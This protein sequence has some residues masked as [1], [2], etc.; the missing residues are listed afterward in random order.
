MK[1]KLHNLRTL[2]IGQENESDQI[3]EMATH[4]TDFCISET[5]L[6]SFK[7]LVSLLALLYIT[8]LAPQG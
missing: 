3:T 2:T 5:I 7:F 4:I 6:Y 1:K 8:L